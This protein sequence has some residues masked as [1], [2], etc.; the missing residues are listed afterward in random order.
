MVS[1]IHLR[2]TVKVGAAK[3]CQERFVVLH[4]LR[5]A[6]IRE[7]KDVWIVALYQNVV[8]LDISMCYVAV[9]EV[10][11]SLAHLRGNCLTVKFRQYVPSLEDRLKI[12]MGDKLHQDVEVFWRLVMFNVLYDIGL[13]YFQYQ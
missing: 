13:G 8:G 5:K 1:G 7:L 9:M 2:R 6:E 11:Q 4:H 12:S 10:L 3:G